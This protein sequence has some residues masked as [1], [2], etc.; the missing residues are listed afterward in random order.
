VSR[1]DPLPPWIVDGQDQAVAE[2]PAAA[3]AAAG[4]PRVSSGDVHQMAA[5]KWRDRASSC[6]PTSSSSP[7]ELNRLHIRVVVGF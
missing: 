3:A 6:V 1:A 2:P 4:D 5:V 7:R